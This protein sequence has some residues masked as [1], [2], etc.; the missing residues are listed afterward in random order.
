MSCCRGWRTPTPS[1]CGGRLTRAR[2]LAR[3]VSFV[4]WCLRSKTACRAARS[5]KRIDPVG[6]SRRQGPEGPDEDRRAGSTA[7]VGLR[8]HVQERR[9]LDAHVEVV[10]VAGRRIAGRAHQARCSP[11]PE[12]AANRDGQPEEADRSSSLT[13]PRLLAR[14][15]LAGSR[16]RR[17]P[18]VGG[19]L[20]GPLRQTRLRR[21]AD[22][23][24]G[25]ALRPE[26]VC[27]PS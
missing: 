19:R 12:R 25:R 3:S 6:V 22:T 23:V 27:G 18:S 2:S 10:R 17:R 1:G 16:P 11:T 9:H 13:G 15:A 7:V 4:N 20:I 8:R 5:A 21:V 26:L 24:S 14:T